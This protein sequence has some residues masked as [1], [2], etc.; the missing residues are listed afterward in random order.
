MV[1]NRH[2]RGYFME[3]KS[4]NPQSQYRQIPAATRYAVARYLLNGLQPG[5]FLSAVL[6][7]QL[8]ES[9]ARADADNRRNLQLL[10]GFLFNEVPDCAHG[11]SDSI[12][13]W[14]INQMYLRPDVR[15][16]IIKDVLPQLFT[17]QELLFVL[18]DNDILLVE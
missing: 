5:G 9:M 7:N 10:L 17:Q 3:E 18:D 11:Q 15:A 6:R 12:D 14:L 2:Q 16:K 13:K 4:A 1:V 8:R